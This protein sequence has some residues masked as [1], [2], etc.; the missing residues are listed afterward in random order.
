MIIKDWTNDYDKKIFIDFINDNIN[1]KYDKIKDE[2]IIKIFKRKVKKKEKEKEK[3]N[4]IYSYIS[5]TLYILYN[6]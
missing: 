5:F 2:K 1:D 3:E 4:N 6:T